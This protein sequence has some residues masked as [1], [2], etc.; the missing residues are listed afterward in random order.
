MNNIVYKL[1]NIIERSRHRPVGY[2]EDV[3]SKGKIIGEYIEI[4]YDEA[5]K[6]VNKYSSYSNGLIN[7]PSSNSWGPTLWGKL[8]K[9]TNEYNLD[10]ES[11]EIW[12][13]DFIASIPC[14]VCRD[15]FS[16][17]N[18]NNPADLSSRKSYIEWAVLVHNIVNQNLGKPIFILE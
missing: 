7:E 8:H 9:R 17:I 11:E 4:P 1:K 15:H 14:K 12:L 6:L 16:E 13:R 18:K 10:S 5:I 2:Y 3:I